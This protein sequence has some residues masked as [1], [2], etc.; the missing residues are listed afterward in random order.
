[1]HN[2][3]WIA[4]GQDLALVHNLGSVADTKVFAHAVVGD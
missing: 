3:L 1:L 2:L 4:V